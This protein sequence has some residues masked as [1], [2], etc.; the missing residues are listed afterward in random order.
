MQPH[1][2]GLSPVH[3]HALAA[4]STDRLLPPV[5]ARPHRSQRALDSAITQSLFDEKGN[6]ATRDRAQSYYSAQ[7]MP[8]HER[9]VH[10]P[11]R[12]RHRK[13]SHPDNPVWNGNVDHIGG[14][15]CNSTVRVQPIYM[16][17]PYQ[18]DSIDQAEI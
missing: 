10:H 18:P 3:Q 14:T 6:I 13:S 16:A 8:S 5:P 7:T 12:N 11:P 1:R 4:S 15:Y 2:D 17:T 9:R